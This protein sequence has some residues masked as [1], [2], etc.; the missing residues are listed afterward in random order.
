MP[1]H[2]LQLL[3]CPVCAPP[4]VLV[5][6]TTLHCGHTVCSA[7]VRSH[8]AASS[9][10]SS[11]SSSTSL[12]ILP[13]CPL[14]TCAPAATVRTHA[15]RPNIP[16]ASRVVYESAPVAPVPN[17]RITVPH[18][19]VDVT[20]SKLLALATRYSVR[21]PHTPPRVHEGDSSDSD[22]EDDLYAAPDAPPRSSPPSAHA[23]RERDTSTSPPQPPRK[24][25]RRQETSSLH[26]TTPS[27]PPSSR[28]SYASRVPSP[29]PPAARFEKDVLNE[30]TCEICFA[31]F[32]Q[33][34]TTPCQHTFC[35]KCLQ[36]S[37]DHSN[38]CPLCRQELPGFAYV[39]DHA[40]NRVVLSIIFKAFPELYRERGEAIEA[41]ERDARLDTPI[42]VAQLSFPGMPT[43]LHFFEPRYRL[44]LRRCLESPNPSFGMIM[45]PRAPTSTA[46]GGT[47]G[48]FGY[49]TML[50]IRSVQMLRDGRSMV[51]TWGTYRFRIVER[52]TLDGYMVGRIER[53]DDYPDELDEPRSRSPSPPPAS[54]SS[55]SS[56]GL[57][58]WFTSSTGIGASSTGTPASASSGTHRRSEP[59]PIPPARRSVPNGARSVPSSGIRGPRDA[60]TT[61][62]MMATCHAFLAQLRQ[63]TAPWVVQRLNNTYGPMPTDVGSFSFWMA[64]VLPIDES[65]K[66]KLL[67]IK[68][69][70]LRLRLVVHWVEQLN[71]NWW[72]SSGCVIL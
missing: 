15:G 27:P 24:R 22:D 69:P 48:D 6:P 64:L 32:F 28:V 57:P 60:P 43:L 1:A 5:A 49:G 17:A 10:A 46:A 29:T 9:S 36:R 71:S 3:H 23:R 58:S 16:A 42:F 55:D 39:Q 50:E 72:F 13:S 65:E 8:P 30:L 33:P 37:L 56:S 20:V 11:A 54:P 26:S 40:C 35:A 70:R 61:A 25:R 31:L 12:P 41:E 21:R 47:A 51:E 45:P 4:A 52:G 67:P 44:M 2:L 68:S 34:I 53:I 38:S 63:G 18:P 66:A 7:H 14:P 59:S 62:E 19:R